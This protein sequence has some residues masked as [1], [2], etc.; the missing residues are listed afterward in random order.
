MDIT[1]IPNHITYGAT[2]DGRIFCLRTEKELHLGNST[3]DYK[4]VYLTNKEGTKPY[5]V[6]RLI[7]LTFIPNPDNKPEIDHIDRDRT[8]NN[9]SNLRWANDEEQS[10][11]RKGW[12]QFPKFIHFEKDNEKNRTYECF[13]IHIKNTTLKYSKRFPTYIY[14]IEQVIECRNKIL[15][16]HNIPIT[17]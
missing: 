3:N 1:P 12:G 9:V 5:S 15:K 11:N 4:R 13:R 6:A 14:T 16:E 7:G 8:N 10:L 2:K 17:D